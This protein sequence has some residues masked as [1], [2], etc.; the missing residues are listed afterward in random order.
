MLTI[1]I[2]AIIS[3]IKIPNMATPLTAGIFVAISA[4]IVF[5]RSRDGVISRRDAGLLLVIYAVFIVLQ[6]VFEAIG[7]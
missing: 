2:I 7:S 5:L 6:Y 1:G 4:V 3:P